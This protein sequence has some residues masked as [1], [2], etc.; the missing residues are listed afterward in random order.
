MR[1][2]IGEDEGLL[3]EALT[4]AL[5][6]WDVEVAASAGTPT[7]IVRLVDE[8]RPDVVILD[9]HMPPD[10]TDEGLRAAERIRAAHPDI[11]LLLLSHYAEVVYAERLLSLQPDTRAVGYLLK[12][13]VG[14]L[15]N[16]VDA[17]RRVSEGDIVIDPEIINRLM[18]RRRRRNPLD[19]LTPQERRVL[20]LVV[21]GRTNRGVAEVLSCSVATVEKHLGA[22]NDKLQLRQGAGG[23]A[24][25]LRVLAVLAY[26]RHNDAP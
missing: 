21:E 15:A 20:A 2:V 24:V 5:E 18:S 9:I 16:L 23:T 17:L 7:E 12:T 13:Q 19:R 6:Q 26:L 4:G 10:F 22:I 11:G 25:N 8:V 1:V 3:R 14:S